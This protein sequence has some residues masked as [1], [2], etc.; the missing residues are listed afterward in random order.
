M[1]ANARSKLSVLA[2][3]ALASACNHTQ[4]WERSQG[5]HTRRWDPDHG[6]LSPTAAAC[7]RHTPQAARGRHCRPLPLQHLSV[8]SPGDACRTRVGPSHLHDGCVC[9]R[10]GATP[11]LVDSDVSG[12]LSGGGVT[13]GQ[14]GQQPRHGHG[15]RH[16]DGACAE[17]SHPSSHVCMAP[18]RQ[19][20]LR[21]QQ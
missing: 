10:A 12:G 5:S 6:S 11:V 9:G 18:R 3:R 14:E 15:G 21:K 8:L 13:H 19:H 7:C 16:P 2:V 4:Q 17:S 1:L 20:E